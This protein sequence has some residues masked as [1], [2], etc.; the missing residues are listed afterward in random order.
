MVGIIMD[1]DITTG[2]A[3]SIMDMVGTIT[4]VGMDITIITGVGDNK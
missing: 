1:G 2:W 4:M 3:M